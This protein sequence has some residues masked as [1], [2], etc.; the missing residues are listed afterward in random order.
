MRR[1][2]ALLATLALAASA[3]IA[4]GTAH[5]DATGVGLTL[6]FDNLAKDRVVK[7][8]LTA[9]SASGVT[10][11]QAKMRYKSSTAEPYATVDLK[12]TE[13]TDNDGV[14]KADFRPDI[15]TRPGVTYVQVVI[16]TADG[17][18]VTRNSGFYD[19]YT[20]LLDD[21]TAS[22][23]V[24]D[25]ENSDLTLRGRVM[26][27][28]DRE[29]APQPAPGAEVGGPVYRAPDG[30]VTSPKATAGED[31]SF[32]MKYSGV[33]SARAQVDRR[34][35]LCGASGSAPLT[36]NKQATETT[37]RLTPASTVAPYTDMA[38]EG[39]VV[40]RGS[41]GLVP[42]ADVEVTFDVPA[43]VADSRPQTVRTAAD[44]TFRAPFK[45]G[46]NAGAS[47]TVTAR[48]AD[49]GFLTGGQVDLGPLNVRNISKISTF[50]AYPEPLAYG[51]SIV[52]NGQLTVEP[53]W[54]NSTNL[55]VVLEFSPD[56]KTWTGVQT[57]TLA[58]PGNFSFNNSTPVK[59]D[60]YWR[61]RYA[62]SALNTPAVS[63]PDYV[64]VKYRTQMYNFNASPEPVKKG[65][66]ITV[67][68]LLYRFRDTAGPAPYAPVSIYFKPAG[69]STWTKMAVAKTA[70]NGWFKKTFTAYKDGT[71][72]A[73]YWE[74]SGY[75]GSNAPSDY[76]DVR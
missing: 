26:I 11:V 61:T 2:S 41:T 29:S 74:S 72:L 54:T 7:L 68:G 16:T 47:A 63:Q 23:G 31:G 10:G 52:A 65:G 46:R 33:A 21:L 51:D 67:Q 44:G 58:R 1:S 30:T 3:L 22:P 70:S 49:T 66:T 15:E 13:G 71:W 48:V 38:V 56:G 50:N 69:S 5:A 59:K 57:Q 64:D 55:P 37:A 75:L 45:A 40:R 19:C 39:K 34:D 4:P 60:G 9:Q 17:A 28:K 36:V 53:D 62:G 20:T 42:A 12:R 8:T 43:E 27:Q 73:R 6:A 18:T 25:I 32:A 14:W 35:A 76:V 24:I